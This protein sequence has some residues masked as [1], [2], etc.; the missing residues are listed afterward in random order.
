MLTMLN[1]LNQHKWSANAS[2]LRAISQ[3]QGA[4]KDRELQKLMHHILVANRF[5]LSLSMEHAFAVEEE[6]K[7]PGSL[8]AITARYQE[9][10]AQESEWISRLQE[11]D[12][13]RQLETSYMPGSRF[14]VAEAM[15]QV[16]MHS[17]G[18]RA[19]CATMLRRAGGEP[20][21]MDFIV[22]LKERPSP[23]W[24]WH[25]PPKI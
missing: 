12:L 18:H 1:D 24:S 8:E 21:V 19:Q 6:S 13:A 23:D 11:V 15:M 3:N 5:W 14:S 4:A 16:C 22:W 9:T 10:F 17:H 2:L 25:N 20:P 7:V